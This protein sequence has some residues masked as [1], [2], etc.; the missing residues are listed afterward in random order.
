MPPKRR[1]NDDIDW[2]A[3]LD[4]KLSSL[5][6]KENFKELKELIL[7]QNLEI[8]SLRERVD[9][10]DVQISK[11]NDKIGVLTG[12]IDTLKKVQDD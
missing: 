8:Q 9:K 3:I 11:L 4:E 7:A 6:S 12:S 5:A 2:D 10:Q 1:N